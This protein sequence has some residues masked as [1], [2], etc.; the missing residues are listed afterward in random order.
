MR[1]Y[2]K[3]KIA[4]VSFILCLALL[5]A[6]CGGGTENAADTTATYAVTSSK[7]SMTAS[8]TALT[9]AEVT[10]TQ[11]VPAPTLPDIRVKT[12]V[13]G[14]Y[15]L[16]EEKGSIYAPDFCA[17][18]DL[19]I[20]RYEKKI[21]LIDV[22][23]GNVL[24]SAEEDEEYLRLGLTDEG[25]YLVN[26]STVE[27]YDTA[28]RKI[29]DIKLP[30]DE[31]WALYVSPDTKYILYSAKDGT[32]ILDISEG[33]AAKADTELYVSVVD[34]YSEDRFT[35]SDYNSDLYY[36]YAD[37]RTEKLARRKSSYIVGGVFFE[38]N[39]EGIA[40]SKAGS[41]STKILYGEFEDKYVS[42]ADERF[43]IASDAENYYRIYD[44]EKNRSTDG[45]D[46]EKICDIKACGGGAFVILEYYAENRYEC[47]VLFSSETEFSIEYESRDGYEF[48]ENY[49]QIFKDPEGDEE[50]L[51]LI[52]YIYDRY[53]VRVFFEL[54]ENQNGQLFEYYFNDFTGDKKR[55]LND[56]L[57]FMKLSPDD[58]WRQV[59]DGNECY[60]Y[61]CDAIN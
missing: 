8:E 33:A 54:K 47:Y 41:G 51:E 29:S 37:G 36:L 55:I 25:Y 40:V 46:L 44:T 5:L 43:F 4:A 50:T 10:T 49:V 60:I 28:G 34:G 6:S 15:S 24:A 35:I 13:Q 27:L 48:P 45:I 7:T 56:L 58:I 12:P 22:T 18:G 42:A 2:E 39:Y 57:E 38:T 9:T 61:F 30:A 11:T 31:L 16:A 14:L 21:K 32:F 53:H 3:I 23:N 52:S 17:Y 1:S 26:G 20:Y 19:L 59:R